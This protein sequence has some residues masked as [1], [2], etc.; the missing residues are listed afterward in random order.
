MTWRSDIGL[1]GSGGGRGLEGWLRGPVS[2]G[3]RG[4]AVP[5][6]VRMVSAIALADMPLGSSAVFI[7]EIR[8]GLG[9]S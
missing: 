3:G 7:S 5:G 4:G 1:G 6:G 8:S 2:G 9:G